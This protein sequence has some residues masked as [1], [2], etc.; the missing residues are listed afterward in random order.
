MKQGFV[1]SYRFSTLQETEKSD[2]S[3]VEQH[4]GMLVFTK[5][6]RT[7]TF[8]CGQNILTEVVFVTKLYSDAGI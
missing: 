8:F 3:S 6:V 5:I 1:F 7:S 4:L 2:R